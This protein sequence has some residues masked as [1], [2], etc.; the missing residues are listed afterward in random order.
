[1]TQLNPQQVTEKYNELDGASF[2]RWVTDAY[3]QSIGGSLTESNME[4]LSSEQHA[5][6][7]YRYVM[8]E[9]MEGGFIQLIV[10][11][12]AP[13][14]LEGPFPYVGKREWGT[15]ASGTDAKLLKDFSKL[16]YEVKKEFH[17]HQQELLADMSEEEF[18]ALYE[19]LEHLNELGDDFLDDYQEKLTP[20]VAQLI[21]RTI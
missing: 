3:L 15:A 14:V 6:L 11:G 5:F 7:C 10:N 20:I 19:Q 21:L 9:V 18:M 17:K 16:I 8:D 4:E 13:Y 1:M 2:I 12:Y